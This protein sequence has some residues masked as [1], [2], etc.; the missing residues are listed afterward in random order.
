[1]WLVRGNPGARWP[2]SIARRPQVGQAIGL[3][4]FAC[5][6]QASSQQRQIEDPAHHGWA[7]LGVGGAASSLSCRRVCTEVVPDARR[8]Q[9]NRP[10]HVWRGPG[11]YPGG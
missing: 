11:Y 10:H 3:M 2:P 8:Y 6:R 7:A 4:L 1:M 5:R 9:K